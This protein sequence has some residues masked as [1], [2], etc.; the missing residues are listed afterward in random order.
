MYGYIYIYSCNDV[1]HI[2]QGIA[3]TPGCA[4]PW[5]TPG[6]GLPSRAEEGYET[7]SSPTAACWQVPS[8]GGGTGSSAWAW[9]SEDPPNR[10]RLGRLLPNKNTYGKTTLFVY[11]TKRGLLQ[12]LEHGFTCPG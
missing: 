10:L 12:L 9:W 3:T 6:I 2:R 11:K 5:D 8:R 7:G 1:K 4:R